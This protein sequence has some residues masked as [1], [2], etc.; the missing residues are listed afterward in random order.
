MEQKIIN[1]EDDLINDLR[2]AGISIS[3]VWD[4]VNTNARYPEAISTLLNHLNRDYNI[5]IKEG[6]VRALAVKEAKCVA[7]KELLIEYNNR[8]VEDSGYRWAIG[9]TMLV[10]ITKNE[11]DAVIDIVLDKKN[12]TSRQMFVLA[13]AKIYNPKIE[14]VL[15]SLLDDE[16]VVGH[17]ISV[18]GKKKSIKAKSKIESLLSSKRSFIRSEAKKALERINREKK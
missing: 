17:A 18:L 3:S 6:I 2:T 8:P 7:C 9:S 14:D 15:I 1:T 10:V 5:R 13:L 4:L 12:G 16:D 11:M